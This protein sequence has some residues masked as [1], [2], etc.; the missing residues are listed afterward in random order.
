M[1]LL[2]SSGPCGVSSTGTCTSTVVAPLLNR[3]I[4]RCTKPDDPLYMCKHAGGIETHSPLH[5]SL[6]ACLRDGLLC[7]CNCNRSQ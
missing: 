3:Y 6:M 1:A 5:L 7:M 2:S 4:D